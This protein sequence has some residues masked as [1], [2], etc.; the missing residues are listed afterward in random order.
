MNHGLTVTPLVPGLVAEFEEREA[1][2]FAQLPWDDYLGLP[3][4]ERVLAVAHY[5]VKRDFDI[6]LNDA[7]ARERRRREKAEA[8]KPRRK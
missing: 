4:G 5:R 7:V 6:H 3:R 8:H 2:R 1:A